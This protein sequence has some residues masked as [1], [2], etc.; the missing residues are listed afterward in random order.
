MRF[1][2]KDSAPDR[3]KL[4][5]QVANANLVRLDEW[6]DNLDESIYRVQGADDYTT[7]L[8]AYSFGAAAKHARDLCRWSVLPFN[9]AVREAFSPILFD[10]TFQ[11]AAWHSV[12]E[13]GAS[14]FVVDWASRLDESERSYVLSWAGSLMPSGQMGAPETAEAIIAEFAHAAT[15]GRPIYESA[16]DS[17]VRAASDGAL[18]LNSFGNQQDNSGTSLAWAAGQ[19][20]LDKAMNSDSFGERTHPAMSERAR[21][22]R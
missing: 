18:N 22:G 21:A 15:S 11:T 4:R 13:T 6:A 10:A 5:E 17:A 9:R 16:A 1:R 2:K 7:G 8:Y 20:L 19:E 3:D 12:L 14:W